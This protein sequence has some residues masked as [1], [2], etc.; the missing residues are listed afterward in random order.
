MSNFPQKRPIFRTILLALLFLP[1][2][3]LA[4]DLFVHNEPIAFSPNQ[5][6]SSGQTIGGYPILGLGSDLFIA[7]LKAV[8]TGGAEVNIPIG[9]AVLVDARM[10]KFFASVEIQANLAEHG[11]VI[12]WRDEP[13]KGDDFL[14]KRSTGGKFTDINCVTIS[15]RT[16][17][18]PDYPTVVSAT[19]TRYTSSAR[20]LTYIVNIN[21]EFF[22]VRRDAEP[23]PATNGWHKTLV[24]NDPKKVEF[25]AG[26]E[27][28]ATDVQDRM[29]KA[30]DQDID[31]FADIPLI[32]SYF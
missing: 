7:Y 20:R 31:A 10:N 13:C 12:D 9:L 19:F 4:D 21:P 30:I 32:G 11:R 16:Q 22:D 14:W 5:K 24:Q 3:A 25:L 15:H 28:W 8:Q 1:Y 26:M 17:F 29:D 2:L 27:K 6:L 18:L 23:N